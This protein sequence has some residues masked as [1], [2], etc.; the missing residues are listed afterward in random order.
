M[1][2]H[3]TRSVKYKETSTLGCGTLKDFFKWKCTGSET[4]VPQRMT[5]IG[6][7]FISTVSCSELNLTADS[8][9]DKE[10]F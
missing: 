4:L 2:S 1:W 10:I 9:L 5:A 8:P 3:G 6:T 7:D